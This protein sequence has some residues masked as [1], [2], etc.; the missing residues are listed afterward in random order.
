VEQQLPRELLYIAD[1]AFL[2]GTAAEITSVRSVDRITVG[3]E[4]PGPITRK[5]QNAFFAIL[6]G[7]A[8]DPHSW[9]TY[10]KRSSQ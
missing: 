1:E 4:Q 7:D 3:K 6:S 5:L 8:P 10:V 9:L 2:T